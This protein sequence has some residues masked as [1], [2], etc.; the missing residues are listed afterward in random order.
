MDRLICGDVGF[1][2][3]EVAIRASFVIASS[4]KQV[5]LVAPTTILVEQHFKTFEE[6]FKSFGVSI[7]SLSRM[8]SNKN[9]LEIKNDLRNGKL[10]IVIGTHALLSKDVSFFNLG[11]IIIDEEQHF[12]VSQK[13][14][15]KELQFDI[16][17]LTLSATPIPRTLQLSLTGIKDLSLITTPPTNRLAV[18]TFINEWDK[19]TLTDAINRELDRNGQI[20]VV[21]PRIKDIDKIFKLIEKMSSKLMISIAHGKLNTNDLEKS[22]INFYQKKSNLLISTNIIESGI[23]IPNANTLIV[24]NADLFGLSQLYQLRGRVGRSDKRAYAY[25]TT[26]KGKILNDN[27]NERLK[28]LKTLDNLGAGF[29]LANYDLDIRG[30]GNLLGDEQSGQIRDIGYEL[31]QK[32]LM[33]TINNLKKNKSTYHVNW[34]P[35]INIGKPVL[36]PEGYVEDLATRMSLYR[37]IGDLNSNDEIK[38]FI[39]ELNERFGPPP[40]EV[41]NLIYTISLKIICIKMNVNFIDIGPKA[42]LIGFRQQSE[43]NIPKILKWVNYNKKNIKFR[44]DEKIVI[45][46]KGKNINRFKLLKNYLKEINELIKF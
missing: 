22:I 9:K 37:K 40:T 25:L 5:A 43:K 11:M 31:Y 34:S 26:Q 23:D 30:A 4:G 6:R 13:E 15:L 10:S 41:T 1:G 45:A 2:K 42:L 39:D 12:G 28:V 46:L 36:I 44:N 38:N 19:V 3:T 17:V 7:K 18:R 27:A 32:M 8:T 35:T 21:C 14:R 20:F 24:Y 33:E 16:H 29:S